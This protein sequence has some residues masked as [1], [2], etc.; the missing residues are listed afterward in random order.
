MV[1]LLQSDVRDEAAQ[2]AALAYRIELWDAEGARM[3]AVLGRLH[4]A[5]LGFAC[6]YGA[7]REYVDRRIVLRHGEQVVAAFNP[8]SEFP[9]R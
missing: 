3:E 4:S 7:L 2:D 5:S 1:E 9:A 8:S 6:Y